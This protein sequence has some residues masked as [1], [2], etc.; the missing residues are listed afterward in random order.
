MSTRSIT[1]NTS[2]ATLIFHKNSSKKRSADM[3][4]PR[5]G[6][7]IS[8]FHRPPLFFLRVTHNLRVPHHQQNAKMRGQFLHLRGRIWLGYESR[9]PKF[10]PFLS[11]ENLSLPWFAGIM[12]IKLH[13]DVAL[14]SCQQSFWIFTALKWRISWS[15]QGTPQGETGQLP[16]KQNNGL[17]CYYSELK[18]MTSWHDVWLP[19]S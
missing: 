3:P 15:G 7:E 5:V 8:V 1:L 16:S 14:I 11:T 18:V 12:L 9:R 17:L 4:L 19:L 6:T 13:F 2:I 10:A